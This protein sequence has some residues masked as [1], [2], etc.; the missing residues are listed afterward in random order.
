MRLTAKMAIIILI[1]SS[2]ACSKVS[3]L[4]MI[5]NPVT[6]IETGAWYAIALVEMN[7]NF[8]SLLYDKTEAKFEGQS[9]MP[10]QQLPRNMVY[11][12]LP[13]IYTDHYGEKSYD[14]LYPTM[15]KNYLLFN[16]YGT[17]T[18]YVEAAD[19]IIMVNVMES[20]QVMMGTNRTSISVSIM[21]QDE[22]PVFHAAT[23]VMS[24]SDKNFYYYPSKEARPVKYLTMKGFEWI[25]SEAVPQAF[26]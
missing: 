21:Q 25:F 17:V 7:T 3:D 1:L 23:S 5:Y 11:Y 15:M 4:E 22:T 10:L 19:Y 24:K 8:S 18:E 26:E 13:T 20:P 16:N 12:I 2:F 9:V 14:T 6:G